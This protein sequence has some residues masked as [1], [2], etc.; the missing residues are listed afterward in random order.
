MAVRFNIDFPA[1]RGHRLFLFI[2][3]SLTQIVGGGY[4]GI[5]HKAVSVLTNP[6]Q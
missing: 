1:A 6:F 3:V 5:V 4:P 2:D